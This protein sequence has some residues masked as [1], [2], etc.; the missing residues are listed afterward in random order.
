MK[1]SRP[2]SPEFLLMK[3]TS[4]RFAPGAILSQA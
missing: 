4:L 3:M 1:T 2:K